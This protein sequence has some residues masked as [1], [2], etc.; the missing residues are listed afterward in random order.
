M[1]FGIERTINLHALNPNYKENETE[2]ISVSDCEYV[3]NALKRLDEICEERIKK[4][5]IIITDGGNQ[6]STSSADNTPSKF[7]I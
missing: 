4:Y 2:T 6:D 7:K 5:Q 1:K 3:E